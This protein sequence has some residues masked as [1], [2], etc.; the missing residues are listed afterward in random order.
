MV[1]IRAFR[2]MYFDAY[3]DS[4]TFHIMISQYVDVA[5]LFTSLFSFAMHCL[6][7]LQESLFSARRALSLIIQ[8]PEE[9]LAL[10]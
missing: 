3:L 6:Q 1:A 10:R 4:Q 5:L 9:T 2:F 7:L 8:D